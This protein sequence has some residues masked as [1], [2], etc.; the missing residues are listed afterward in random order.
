M[1]RHNFPAALAILLLTVSSAS[2]QTVGIAPIFVVAADF[3]N[4]GLLD[5]AV[6]NT[7]LGSGSI[8]ILIG[9]GDG[10]FQPAT[11]IRAGNYPRSIAV[12]DFNRDGKLD[13][14]VANEGPAGGGGL[15]ILLGNGDGTF[16]PPVYLTSGVNPASLA[17]ADFNAD[18]IVDLAVANS[19]QFQTNPPFKAGSISV[20]LGKGDGTFGP[21]S[22][23]SAGTTPIA[24]TVADFNGDGKPDLAAAN[25]G[26]TSL[27]V[28]MG[29]GDGTF[30]RR[31][32]WPRAGNR[33]PSPAQT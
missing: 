1:T 7:A 15:C 21:A 29:N 28:L 31:H 3:N 8:S 9:N 14:A 22:F 13:L 2:A 16:L 33:F 23:F 26:G 10:T 6:A 25:F 24:I 11:V 30:R 19:E 17:A 20:L 32:S 4:D 27:A 5:L 12:A 18:G